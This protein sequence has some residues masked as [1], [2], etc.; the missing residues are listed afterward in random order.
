M[1]NR[2]YLDKVPRSLKMKKIGAGQNGKCYLTNKKQVYKEYY[3]KGID[4]EIT[5]RLTKL[6]YEGFTFPKQLVIVDGVF[7]GYIKDYVEGQTID[8]LDRTKTNIGDFLE[9]LKAFETQLMEFSY[10]TELD[11]CDLNL[12]NLVYTN[13]NRI[14]NIDTDIIHPF[15]YPITNPYFEN[16]KELSSSLQKIF[17]DGEFKSRELQQLQNEC[18]VKGFM[19]PSTFISR[20]LYRLD[21]YA[22]INT[23]DDY[24]QG[25][26]LLRK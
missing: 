1:E 8:S 19:R 23:I 20:A 26:V 10:D 18:L 13:D 4:D 5:D 17:L 6:N 9:A 24:E 25:L 14:V 11:V 2:I 21:G 7:K 16:L 22:D 15:I 12:H 3:N